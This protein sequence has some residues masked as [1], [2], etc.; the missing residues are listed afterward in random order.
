MMMNKE[1][2][3]PAPA[4]N[5]YARLLACLDRIRK[6]TDFIPDIGL[7]LGTGLGSLADAIA[8]EA[9]I[10]YREIEGF[11]VSTAPSHEGRFLLGRIGSVKIAAMK[12]RIHY[13]EGYDM[14]DVVLP[15][16]VLGLLGAKV[17]V[18]TN[19]AGGI[20]TSFAPG[21]IM[22]IT[23]QITSF[24][25]SPLIGPNLDALGPRFPDMT[26]IYDQELCQLVR[27]AA[28]EEGIPLKEGT[29]VQTTGPQFET[30]KEINMFRLLGASAVG[31]STA[32]EAVA[33]RHMGLR[34]VGLSLI[35]NMAAG[36][37][38]KPVSGDEVNETARRAGDRLHRLVYTSL[39][40]I[41][42]VIRQDPA[43]AKEKDPAGKARSFPSGR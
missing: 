22:L 31:M 33:A 10:P 24:V 8:L 27:R 6:K 28:A 39:C 26:H 1:Q 19:A 7:V 25:P 16:R 14:Q 30:S 34:V 40:K 4:G 20:P 32:V 9:D 42:Q 13:Y 43:M 41:G 38:D 12:G 2:Q 17:L 15:Q 35:S 5:E 11:P 18:L 23:D 29:Y 3:R 36:I 37:L 21:D